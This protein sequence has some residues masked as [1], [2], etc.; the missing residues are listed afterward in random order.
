MLGTKLARMWE[1]LV[2]RHNII[3]DTTQHNILIVDSSADQCC[4][5]PKS[6]HIDERTNQSV[7]CEGYA[8]DE[9]QKF[10]IVSG[11]SIAYGDRILLTLIKINEEV[12]MKDEDELESLLHPH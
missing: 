7:T 3:N 4:I 8:G 9:R 6:W 12:L 1:K 11:H 10:D 5:T 2:A